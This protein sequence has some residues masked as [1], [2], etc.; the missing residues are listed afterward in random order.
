MVCTLAY[1]PP[2]VALAG[3]EMGK[4]FRI[5]VSNT[6]VILKTSRPVV[7][8]KPGTDQD[9][10][11]DEWERCHILGHSIYYHSDTSFQ[12]IGATKADTSIF[13]LYL[14][15]IKAVITANT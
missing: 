10:G 6:K 15:G 9:L 4:M 3:Q 5:G 7:L 12:I 8:K 14:P 13:S 2:D 1:T 11:T